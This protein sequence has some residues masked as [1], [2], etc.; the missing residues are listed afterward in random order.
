MN[1]IIIAIRGKA[2]TLAL[3]LAVAAALI[4]A[5]GDG[6]DEPPAAVSSPVALAPTAAHTP[7]PAPS[8]TA[9]P[10]NSPT[11]IPTAA[12]A[13]T[14]TPIP[15]QTPA[16]AP[17]PVPTPTLAPTAT[18]TPAPTPRVIRRASDGAPEAAPDFAL[19]TFAGETLRLSDLRGKVVVLNFWASWCPPCRWEMPFFETISQ[20]YKERGVIFLGVAI[21]DTMEDASDFADSVGVTYPLALDAAGETARDYEVLGLPTTFLIDK[22][23]AIQRRLG[24]ANEATLKIFL[25]GQVD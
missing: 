6:G 14:P 9:A 21:S 13:S 22:D 5:C 2:P 15:T 16:S 23:G 10:A 18:S 11:P 7:T 12:P 8:P 24:A 3:I 25:D 20:E 1:A 17:T 4:A 19:E